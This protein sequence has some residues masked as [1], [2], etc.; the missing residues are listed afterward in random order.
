MADTRMCLLPLAPRHD[1]HDH[2]L[3]FWFYSSLWVPLNLVLFAFVPLGFAEA[4]LGIGVIVDDCACGYMY[5][6]SL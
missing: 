3:C 4:N 2:P 5:Y 6:R 1:T